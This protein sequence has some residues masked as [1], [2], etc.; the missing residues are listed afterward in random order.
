MYMYVSH[1]LIDMNAVTGHA[2]THMV[3]NGYNEVLFNLRAPQTEPAGTTWLGRR[4]TLGWWGL[5][6]T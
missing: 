6:E 2:P 1:S 5:E 3:A 4:L